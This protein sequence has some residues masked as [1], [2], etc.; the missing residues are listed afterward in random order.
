MG[1]GLKIFDEES[2]VSKGEQRKKA[3]EGCWYSTGKSAGQA[4]DLSSIVGDTV[5]GV[6]GTG[7]ALKTRWCRPEV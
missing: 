7:A 2:L 1:F 6:L 5:R 3:L 4:L